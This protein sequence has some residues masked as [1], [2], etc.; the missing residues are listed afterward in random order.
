[1]LALWWLYTSPQANSLAAPQWGC[2]SSPGCPKA[3][4]L[5]AC[6]PAG[7]PRTRGW[8]MKENP[9]KSNSVVRKVSWNAYATQGRI[10]QGTTPSPHVTP[11]FGARNI[12]GNPLQAHDGENHLPDT[13][14][15]HLSQ[16]H[17]GIVVQVLSHR[18][19]PH[20]V[21]P[22]GHVKPPQHCQH[23]HTA[24]LQ[25]HRAKLQDLLLASGYQGAVHSR[26]WKKWFEHVRTK[27]WSRD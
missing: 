3:S 10:A 12:G 20:D 1:M 8:K 9:W 4:Q 23:G 27:C 7:N 11:N 24:V 2:R 15:G 6:K 25:L 17:Q 21:I 16:I 5:G 26:L 18:I 22:C 14:H 19:V 13:T